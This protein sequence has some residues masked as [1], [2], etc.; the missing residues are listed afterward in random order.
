MQC[1]CVI[2]I[3]IRANFFPSHFYILL[4]LIYFFIWIDSGNSATSFVL[5]MLFRFTSICLLFNTSRPFDA[6][7]FT[8][9]IFHQRKRTEENI[10][11]SVRSFIPWR[12]TH[13]SIR[14]LW[15][16]LRP[17]L[18][19]IGAFEGVFF[20]LISTKCRSKKFN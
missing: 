15:F 4:F 16:G 9:H 2:D 7:L 12:K 19:M 14:N 8:A 6:L 3:L 20:I 13:R 11:I 17:D 5:M 1:N 10:R 18:Q